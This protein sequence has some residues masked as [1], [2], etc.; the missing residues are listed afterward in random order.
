[1]YDCVCSYCGYKE[2]NTEYNKECPNC[3]EDQ[4][5]EIQMECSCG[6]AFS[7]DDMEDAVSRHH[8][9]NEPGFNPQEFNSDNLLTF[10]HS[11]NRSWC[12]GSESYE[13]TDYYICP[14]GI[15]LE[16]DEGT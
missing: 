11:S 9:E 3:H 4:L 14:C 2:S 6:R 12:Y 15:E 13:W 7:L 8:Q 16:V 5:R 1:M 10:S